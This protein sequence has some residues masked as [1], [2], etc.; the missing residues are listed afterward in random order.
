MPEW[1]LDDER[2]APAAGNA[3]GIVR[4]QDES[5]HGFGDIIASI[6]EMAEQRL[7][8]LKSAHSNNLSRVRSGGG[9]RKCGGSDAFSG[10]TGE[11]GGGVLRGSAGS[12]RSDSDVFPRLPRCGT[13][14]IC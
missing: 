12:R 13:R 4:M 9:K 8:E 10:V 5:H 7:K 6:M 2:R 1:L 11:P 3:P 14:S